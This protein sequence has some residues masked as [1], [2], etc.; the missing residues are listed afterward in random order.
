MSKRFTFK[1]IGFVMVVVSLLFSMI[2]LAACG[3]STETVVEEE[4]V[5]EEEEAA[6]EEEMADEFDWRQ[7]E[8]TEL[9]VFLNE[10][11]MAVAIRENIDEF[12]ELTGIE[13]DYLVVAENEY[14]SKLTVDLTSGAGEFDVFMSGASL[15]WGYAAA[16]QIQPLDP[17]MNDPS[18]TPDDWDYED[19]YDWAIDSQRW[20]GTPGPE[21]LGAGEL[22]ALPINAV[23]SIVTYRK[24][25]FDEYDISP[26]DTWE[27][28]YNVAYEIQE[29]TG[30]EIDGKPFYSVAARGAADITT[31]S[32][33]FVS[34]LFSYGASDFNDDLTPAMNEPQA[35]EYQKIYMDVIKDTGT[36]EWPS[37]MWFDVQN[38]FG[39]GQYAMVFDVADFVPTFEGEGSAVA[40]KLGYALPPAGPDGFRNSFPW[41]WGF[42]MNAQSEGDTAK[43]AWLFIMWASSKDTMVTFA[44]Q[45]TWPTRDSVWNDPAVVAYTDQ[46]GDGE[47]RDVVDEVQNEYAEWLVAPMTDLGAVWTIWVNGLHDYYFEK[48]DMQTIMDRVADDVTE[49]LLSSGT[50]Q[51]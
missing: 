1:R 5:V 23:N 2:F 16:E 32:G 37:Q 4:A 25:V 17:Y 6:D 30:G 43:A 26:P 19:F 11:P 15:N 40:G 18:L 50:L 9:T 13:I 29:K 8:G 42:S 41:C 35:V 36:P 12:T 44:K 45:G 3:P 7:V 31:L 47:F 34:G 48:G 39:S 10:T 21:G 24:D 14:W 51:E 46:F 22:W 49:A 38:G 28:W 33:P 20:D 27:D